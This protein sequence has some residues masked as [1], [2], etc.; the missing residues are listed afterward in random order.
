MSIFR[1][2]RSI[3]KSERIWFRLYGN[4]SLCLRTWYCG[5]FYEEIYGYLSTSAGS[6]YGAIGIDWI[7]IV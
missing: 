7:V 5:S 2:V 6:T 3:S 4:D 1:R